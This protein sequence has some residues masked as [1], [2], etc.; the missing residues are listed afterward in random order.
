MTHQTA[1]DAQDF[2]QE[3]RRSLRNLVI[4]TVVLFVALAAV[5]AY[6]YVVADQ[7]RQ[8]VCNLSVDLEHRVKTSEDFLQN[9]PDKIKQFG[10]TEAQVQK[11]IDN[12]RRTLDALGVVSC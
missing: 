5:G 9:H 8:A 6:A 7:N 10:F 11:E 1:E 4:A 2:I 3:I 12:Q